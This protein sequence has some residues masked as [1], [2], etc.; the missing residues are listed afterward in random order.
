VIWL[1]ISLFLKTQ[2]LSIVQIVLFLFSD[3][4]FLPGFYLGTIQRNSHQ[5]PAM[6][7]KNPLSSP[8]PNLGLKFDIRRN[9]DLQQNPLSTSKT[10]LFGT[11]NPEFS[12]QVPNSALRE[13]KRPAF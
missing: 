9:C 5:K 8:L 2:Q 13:N 11:E 1:S 10:H 3:P 7:N 12:V 6:C 4:F